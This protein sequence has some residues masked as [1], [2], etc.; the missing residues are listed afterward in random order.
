LRRLV[1]AADSLLA[2]GSRRRVMQAY[3]NRGA[4]TQKLA[5]PKV[6]N[7]FKVNAS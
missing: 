5:L 2:S 4:G 1:A 3:R 6:R 7:P